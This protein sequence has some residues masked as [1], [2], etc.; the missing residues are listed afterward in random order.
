MKPFSV[1][2]DRI[3]PIGRVRFV[4]TGL[5]GEVKQDFEVPNLVPNLG[6]GAIAERMKA[7]PAIAAMS[8][9][10]VGTGNNGPGPADSQLV[11]EIGRVALAGT[12]VAAAVIT[13]TAVFGPGVGTGA[14]QEAGIFNAGAAGVLLARTI[15]ATINKAAGD[16][17]NVTWTVTIG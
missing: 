17:L 8:H 7:A 3:E 12:V 9:M 4:L 16:T 10:A 13:Y 6:K 11:A 14:L 2:D 1:I 5:D 15:Y